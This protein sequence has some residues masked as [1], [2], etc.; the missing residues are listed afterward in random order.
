VDVQFLISKSL[1]TGTGKFELRYIKDLAARENIPNPPS[2]TVKNP[3][4]FHKL[5]VEQQE[6]IKRDRDRLAKESRETKNRTNKHP[7]EGTGKKDRHFKDNVMK[8]VSSFL[9]AVR[10]LS[11]AIPS[12][13]YSSSQ[14]PKHTSNSRPNPKA[15]LVINL[16]N[17]RT[18][19]DYGVAQK[20]FVFRISTEDGAQ[21]V[22]QAID[23]DEMNDWM[24]V[25][26]EASNQA[27]KKRMTIPIELPVDPEPIYESRTSVYGKDIATL[28]RN[29][30]VPL[31]VEK[32]FT[33][34]EKRGK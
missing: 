16:I 14:N 25:I 29:G 1:V 5:V 26:G 11:L 2:W 8:P 7:N 3:K 32:C 27:L 31:I 30:N 13:W 28:M 22:L 21:Y 34:I 23:Q 20:D 9:K 17:C 15:A 4:P 10:P 6:K 12:S 24:S 18:S 33:E 19:I